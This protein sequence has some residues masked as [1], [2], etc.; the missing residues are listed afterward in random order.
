MKIK[1]IE[2]NQLE[3]CLELIHVCFKTVADKLGFTQENCPGHT[4]F[5]P[6]EKLQRFWDWGFLMFGLF[7]EQEKLCGYVSLS[8]IP[9]RENVLS[10]H[11]LCVLPELRKNGYGKMLLDFTKQ[12]SKELGAEILFVDFIEEHTELKNWY[13]KNDFVHKGTEKYEHLPFTVGKAE[14]VRSRHALLTR[15]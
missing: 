15:P 13:I 9:E 1:L 6:M 7:D 12:K 5:M 4:S 10:I 8:K 2:Q 14:Y 3:E 11:N